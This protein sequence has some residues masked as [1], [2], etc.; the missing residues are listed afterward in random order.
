MTLVS[1]GVG[2]TFSSIARYAK[3]LSTPFSEINNI[4]K[5]VVFNLTEPFLPT[6]NNLRTGTNC[7][8]ISIGS[9]KCKLDFGTQ[10]AAIREELI[11]RGLLQRTVL[12]SIAS[13]M[14]SSIKSI[15]NH[16]LTRIFLTSVIFA[17]AHDKE[18]ILPQFLGG[19]TYGLVAETTESLKIPMILHA[20]NNSIAEIISL[21]S[22]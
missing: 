10:Q 18:N 9:V 16:K 2:E 17:S 19:I 8:F 13:K 7:K 14:P 4:L 12:P 3:P 15:L 22:D 5:T 20:L 1:N 6:T 11:F 21:Y